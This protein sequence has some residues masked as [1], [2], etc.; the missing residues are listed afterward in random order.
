MSKPV[1]YSLSQTTFQAASV[2]QVKS[3]LSLTELSR[4][5]LPSKISNKEIDAGFKRT[6]WLGVLEN[7]K[8]KSTPKLHHT[9]QSK[10]K[11]QL[12]RVLGINRPPKD[13][14]S[15]DDAMKLNKLWLSYMKTVINLED[16]VSRGWNGKPCG[17]HWSGLMTSLYK[18]D[19]HGAHVKVISSRCCSYIGIQGVIILETKNTFQIVGPDNTLKTVPKNGCVFEIVLQ[20]YL[21]HIYG[22][23]F[24]TRS[25]DR[26]KKKLKDNLLLQL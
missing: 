26:S 9:G 2:P 5:L 12:K 6:Y 23:H 25:K 21:F 20:G 15:Y 3:P 14:L 1:Y 10:P 8:T 16:L 11:N 19:Y 18:C 17:K 13:V 4:Q 22:Q 7:K 24:V